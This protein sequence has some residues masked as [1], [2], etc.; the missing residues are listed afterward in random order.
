MISDK[1]APFALIATSFFVNA[2]FILPILVPAYLEKGASIGDFMMI[3]GL[4]S[5]FVCLLEL[6]SGYFGDIFSRKKNVMAGHM[7][8]IIGYAILYL[9][10]GLAAIM[11]QEACIAVALSLFSGTQEAYLFDLLKRLGKENAF[12][13]YYSVQRAV[14]NVGCLIA[15][16]IGT[17]LYARVGLNAVLLTSIG[18]VSVSLI[19][20]C[21]I[22]DVTESVRIVK[23]DKIR[24]ILNITASTYKN[25]FL[26]R[27][28]F[29]AAVFG[30]GTGLAYW[31]LQPIL[32]LKQAPTAL[33][34]VFLTLNQ[35]FRSCWSAVA[36]KILDT[37]GEVKTCALTGGIII[38][39]IGF[40]T[41][42]VLSGSPVLTYA[43]LALM[44]LGAASF[45]LTA[46]VANALINGKIRSDER[47][48]VISVNSMTNRL[49]GGFFF[50]S[51]KPLYENFGTRATTCLFPLIIVPVVFIVWRIAEAARK[52]HS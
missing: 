41:A 37:L 43:C 42:G 44:T 36:A 19:L 45:D 16:G 1:N 47:A 49:L 15:A 5:I 52:N 28:I 33:F 50:I 12:H 10:D 31:G 35:V 29:M 11:A 4:A 51:L 46:V 14:L 24:D 3:Q 18:C 7:F 26:R 21:F 6:P 38:L 9:F 32:I 13:R 2:L 30:V 25:A 17:F 20:L 27:V 34:G 8:Y 39:T 22:P 40:C 23:G 48:T